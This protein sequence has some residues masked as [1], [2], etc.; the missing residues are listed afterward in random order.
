MT[1]MK[2][3]KEGYYKDPDTNVVINKNYEELDMFLNQRER[4]KK[5]KNLEHE[6]ASLREELKEIKVLLRQLIDK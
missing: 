5:L 3:N 4:N 2:T 6:T 1:L